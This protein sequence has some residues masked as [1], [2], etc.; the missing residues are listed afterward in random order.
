MFE[1]CSKIYILALTQLSESD[2]IPQADLNS[3][4]CVKHNQK[5]YR[6]EKMTFSIRTLEGVFPKSG[7]I[8]KEVSK[9]PTLGKILL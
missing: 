4:S 7:T 9:V 6:F 2:E 8:T 1:D 3:A 5:I